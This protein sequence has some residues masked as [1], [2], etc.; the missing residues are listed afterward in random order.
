M[1]PPPSPSS[2][3]PQSQL[4]ILQYLK[5]FEGVGA[6]L[7]APDGTA[8]DKI[9]AFG[10]GIP[11][12]MLQ[13]LAGV[14]TGEFT[15]LIWELRRRGLIA[16]RRCQ[17]WQYPP[18]FSLYISDEK[19]ITVRVSQPTGD[20]LSR[21]FAAITGGSLVEIPQSERRTSTPSAAG[22]L[23]EVI[24]RRRVGDN[25]KE[26][27]YPCYHARDFGRLIRITGAGLDYLEEH[28]EASAGV[29]SPGGVSYAEIVRRAKKE[30]DEVIQQAQLDTDLELYDL[31]VV[32]C[33]LHGYVVD[34][35]RKTRGSPSTPSAFVS[36]YLRLEEFSRRAKKLATE[37]LH[38]WPKTPATSFAQFSEDSAMH[39]VLHLAQALVGAIGW[40]RLGANDAAPLAD[41]RVPFPMGHQPS[42]I[43]IS[44]SDPHPAI[45]AW[46]KLSIEEIRTR[47]L[48]SLE[49]WALWEMNRDIAGIESKLRDE[50][51]RAVQ[52][53]HSR[54]P[55][56][57]TFPPNRLSSATVECWFRKAG[58]CWTLR[59]CRGDMLAE[60]GIFPPRRGFDLIH[61]LLYGTPLLATAIPQVFNAMPAVDAEALGQVA[62]EL[63]RL[64]DLREDASDTRAA[65]LDA[66]IQRGEE[67]LR[68]NMA[69]GGVPKTVGSSREKA[70][71]RV[72][73]AIKEALEYARKF[74]PLWADHMAAS[75]DY[76]CGPIP[77][78]RPDPPV[79]WVP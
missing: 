72:R 71:N 57:E 33:V 38:L 6:R 27:T 62:A 40:T 47:T 1:V 11:S 75:I 19:I 25:W 26:V 37:K 43:P 76:T 52:A 18:Q 45:E 29:N 49:K 2:G 60:P 5:Q 3:V 78:Y 24:S 74:A 51:R 67:Y 46:Q 12:S 55:S 70:M 20:D 59:F 56:V 39:I 15:V 23:I 63:E 68:R 13:A 50:F 30:V 73:M 54:E 41:G 10:I 65:K 79:A 22:V 21:Y 36:T 7:A 9:L 28:S 77:A 58:D 14:S 64:Q 17:T 61:S 31:W 16:S 53:R 69:P 34:I 32:G 66:E 48:P 44:E 42:M 4:R 35:L 8:M